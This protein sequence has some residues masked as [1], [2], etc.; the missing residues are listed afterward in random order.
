MG[1][2][3]SPSG[4][5]RPIILCAALA[6]PDLVVQPKVAKRRKNP[7]T[8]FAWV[9]TTQW[10]LNA[11]VL[12]REHFSGS[13]RQRKSTYG[14]EVADGLKQIRNC[15]TFELHCRSQNSASDL[16]VLKKKC[17]L[18]SHYI[19]MNILPQTCYQGF[20]VLSDFAVV[21]SPLRPCTKQICWCWTTNGTRTLIT[22][23][24]SFRKSTRILV[25]GP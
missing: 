25:A 4:Q 23:P 3:L 20:V 7:A 18:L 22:K 24:V 1:T 21:K 6:S 5:G 11:D 9:S 12:C 14:H 8:K 16:N 17:Y 13:L 2:A 10:V 15:C 19:R